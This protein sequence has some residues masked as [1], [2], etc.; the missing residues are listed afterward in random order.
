MPTTVTATMPLLNTNKPRSPNP[1]YD[2]EY[3]VVKAR[4]ILLAI[5]ML[6]IS[7]AAGALLLY[8]C[9][10]RDPEQSLQG[11]DAKTED[12]WSTAATRDDGEG[13]EEYESDEDEDELEGEGSEVIRREAIVKR[14]AE[15]EAAERNYAKREAM[16]DSNLMEGFDST[17]H[18]G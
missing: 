3:H 5:G 13:Q 4:A 2:Q 1:I 18:L 15:E 12:G 9:V 6:V 10:F 11:A 16:E 8:V 7:L 17:S 14:V